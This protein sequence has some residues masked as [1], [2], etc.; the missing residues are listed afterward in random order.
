MT[1]RAGSVCELLKTA[2]HLTLVV[3]VRPDGDAIGSAAALYKALHKTK[4]VEIFCATEV[5]A[6][7][8]RICGPLPLKQVVSDQSDLIVLLDC[9]E[10]HRTGC[11]DRL[12][13]LRK[14]GAKIISFD[15]HATSGLGRHVDGMVNDALASSTAEVIYDCF[16]QLRLPIDAEAAECLLLGIYTDTGAFR[17]RNTSS[18]TLRI[19]GRLISIGADLDRLQ[20]LFEAPRSLVKTRL[21]GT[22][23][24]QV[25]VNRFGMA[26]A[27]IDA[28]TLKQ[29][30]ATAEDVAGLAN[31]L[32]LLNEARAVLVLLETDKGWRATLRTRH[33][34][35]D[36]RRLAG[37]FG[38]RGTQKA[39]GFLAT[40]DLF[41]SKIN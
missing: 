21:W 30:G 37:Y 39:S 35:V 13:H 10:W 12:K 33:H 19:A 14:N 28:P 16:R 38:G 22:M 6:I 36:L 9:A 3:H 25:R 2:Q 32:A 41:S 29:L 26:V 23:F 20:R 24:S 15:H 11:G 18:R 40:N 4:P 17:H 5:P 27:R 34:G 31:N 1:G 8:Q 7:F